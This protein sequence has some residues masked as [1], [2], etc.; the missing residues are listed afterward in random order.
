MLSDIYRSLD[1][2]FHRQV[3]RAGTVL[4]RKGIDRSFPGST[5][6]WS[7]PFVAAPVLSLPLLASVILLSNVEA[8]L[9]VRERRDGPLVR[10]ASSAIIRDPMRYRM[11]SAVRSFRTV[12][13]ALAVGYAAH[14]LASIV[15]GATRGV[16]DY[17]GLHSLLAVPAL[18]APAVSSYLRDRDPPAV[19]EDPLLA[20]VQSPVITREA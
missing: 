17:D 11:E 1:G 14:G 10:S 8:S 7:V 15:E 18:A 12:P 2:Y 4:D 3:D 16:I 20:Y 13:A 19:E 6:W 9:C 5:Y